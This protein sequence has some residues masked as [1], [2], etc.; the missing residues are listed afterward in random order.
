MEVKPKS[1]DMDVVEEKEEKFL[2]AVPVDDSF[3]GDL[4]LDKDTEVSE[5]FLRIFTFNLF[6]IKVIIGIFF[7]WLV[8]GCKMALYDRWPYKKCTQLV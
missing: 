6:L 5:L 8:F 4:D 2:S 7:I 1:A 3:L